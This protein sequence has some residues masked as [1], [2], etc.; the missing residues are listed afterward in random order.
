[1]KITPAQATLNALRG[2]LTMNE[3]A[4]AIHDATV[5]VR[6]F[7]KPAEVSLTIR[8]EPPKGISGGLAESPI[9]MRAEVEKKLPKLELPITLFYIDDDGNPTQAAPQRQA[10]LGLSIASNQ[11]GSNGNT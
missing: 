4:Q 6:Q 3:L 10:A 11:G 8:I 5:A 9:F 7:G 2:G 1:M